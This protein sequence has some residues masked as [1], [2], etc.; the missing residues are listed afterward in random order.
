MNFRNWQA[1]IRLVF[2]LALAVT[3]VMALL[4]NPPALP[5]QATDKVQHMAAFAALTFLAALGFQGLRLRVIFVAMAALGMA[6]EILQMIPTLHRD[7]QASDW[8]ADC[9]AAAAALLLCGALRWLFSRRQ[10]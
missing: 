4:P 9:A 8:L 3:L 1:W 10:V 5:R 2:W 6:I 7:A